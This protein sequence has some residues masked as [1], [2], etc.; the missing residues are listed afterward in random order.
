MSNKKTRGPRLSFSPT[1]SPLPVTPPN[2]EI[3]L[4]CEIEIQTKKQAASVPKTLRFSEE[5]VVCLFY[6]DE[7]PE[8]VGW[9]LRLAGSDNNSSPS[10]KEIASR[11]SKKNSPILKTRTLWKFWSIYNFEIIIQYILIEWLSMILA[12]F[13]TFRY[14]ENERG[15]CFYFFGCRYQAKVYSKRLAADDCIHIILIFM[16]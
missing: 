2:L 4:G 16:N 13:L 5:V 11:R 1:A 15:L 8:S 9:T 12:S 10:I 3:D 7:P 6:K 14:L